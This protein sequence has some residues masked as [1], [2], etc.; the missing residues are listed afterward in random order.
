MSQWYYAH[1]GQQKGPV[2]ISELQ[3]LASAGDFDPENDLVWREGMDD[4]KPAVTVPELAA[5]FRK[6][7]TDTLV[8]SETTVGHSQPSAVPTF[9]PNPAPVPM[10]QAPAATGPAKSGLAVGSMVCG[11]IAFLTCF[12][13]CAGMPLGIA[14]LALGFIALSK[15][16]QEPAGYTGKGFAKTGIVLGFLALLGAV[17]F[18]A[19]AMYLASLDPVELQRLDWIPPEVREQIQ[20]QLEAQRG[21]EQQP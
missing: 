1:G 7:S 10:A 17:A 6:P 15:I 3:R 20:Q 21:L 8:E 14:A 16:K 18:T 4:W 9:N 19:F 12:L 5:D 2:P 11:I 13:W